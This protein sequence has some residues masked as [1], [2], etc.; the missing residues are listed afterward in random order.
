VFHPGVVERLHV[1]GVR[2]GCWRRGRRT[3][4]ASLR[5]ALLRRLLLLLWRRHLS[6]SRKM[7]AINRR[8]FFALK[9]LGW[10]T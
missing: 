4:T 1:V 2:R 10:S 3:A 9:D 5:P 7:A 6:E 8:S